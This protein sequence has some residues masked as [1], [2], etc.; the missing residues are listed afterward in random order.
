VPDLETHLADESSDH[1]NPDLANSAID[2]AFAVEDNG[3]LRVNG[4][5]AGFSEPA[6]VCVRPAKSSQN[7]SAK[8]RQFA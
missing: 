3:A 2:V 6:P 1:L 8:I 4:A 7:A 5:Q